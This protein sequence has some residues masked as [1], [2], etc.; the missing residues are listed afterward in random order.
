MTGTIFQKLN[1]FFHLFYKL[2]IQITKI[3]FKYKKT[4]IKN[5]FNHKNN[6]KIIQHKTFSFKQLILIKKI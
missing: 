2:S 1:L 4:V 6:K 5:K 3:N